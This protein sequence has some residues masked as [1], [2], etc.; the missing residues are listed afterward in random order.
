MWLMFLKCYLK[1]QVRRGRE[2][3]S[4]LTFKEAANLS[5]YFAAHATSQ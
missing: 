2:K 5:V 3:V 1:A 4:L